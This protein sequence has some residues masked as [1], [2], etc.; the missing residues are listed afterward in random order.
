MTRSRLHGSRAHRSRLATAAT[1][2]ACT[3]LVFLGSSCGVPTDPSPVAIDFKAPTSVPQVP[4]GRDAIAV[5]FVK[6]GKLVRITRY[7][8]LPSKADVPRGRLS[9]V[10]SG[11]LK[12]PTTTLLED[13]PLADWN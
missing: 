12:G 1:A 10:P 3:G 5:Y 13:E 7:K 2:A 4:T 9:V 8:H 11:N 6:D